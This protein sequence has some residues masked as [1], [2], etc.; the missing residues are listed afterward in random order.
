MLVVALIAAAEFFAF[1]A[2]LDWDFWYWAGRD[3]WTLAAATALIYGPRLS[4]G[5]SVASCIGE[6][7]TS[8]FWAA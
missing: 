4:L 2:L 1:A 3:S 5:L 7:R 8:R 6:C